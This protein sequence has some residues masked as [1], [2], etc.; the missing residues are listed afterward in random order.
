VVEEGVQF[1]NDWSPDGRILAFARTKGLGADGRAAGTWDILSWAQGAKTATPI[2]NGAFNEFG[3]TFSPDGRWLAYVSEESGRREVYLRPYPGP[4]ASLQ[5]STDGGD[6][7]RWGRDGKELF[8]YAD[9][10]FMH[11]QLTM[12]R[13]VSASKPAAVFGV[14]YRG[15]VDEPS[16]PSYDVSLDGRRFLMLKA[17]TADSTATRLTVVLN[18][19]EELGRPTAGRA[20]PLR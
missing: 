16:Y 1:P 2:V 15:A 7:P 12:A 3:P 9:S 4:G 20:A 10:A 18:W 19:F 17:G 5:I 6:Q 14:S 8:F 11:V 13:E